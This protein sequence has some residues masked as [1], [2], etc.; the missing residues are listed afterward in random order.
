MGSELS[1]GGEGDVGVGVAA[2]TDETLDE[3][4]GVEAGADEGEG[5]TRD[6]EEGKDDLR[7]GGGGC[8]GL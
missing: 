3:F 1:D 8:V 6:V 5:H 2:V 4:F 7:G